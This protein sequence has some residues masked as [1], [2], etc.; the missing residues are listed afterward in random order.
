MMN[1]I[2]FQGLRIN[3]LSVR[4][5]NADEAHPDRSRIGTLWADFAVQVA[6]YI[7][8]DAVTY[9]GPTPVTLNAMVLTVWW[10]FTLHWL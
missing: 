3:G 10:T 1:I 4:T 5:C 2:E 9:R 8:H 6:P 7:A